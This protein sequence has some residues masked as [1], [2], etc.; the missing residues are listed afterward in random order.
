MPK[1]KTTKQI[2]KRI[3][4]KKS[5]KMDHETCGQDHFNSRENGNTKRNKRKKNQ[6]SKK[7]GLFDLA[8]KTIQ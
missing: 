6:I 7:G 5:G 1:I 3:R 4:I 2:S 8:K